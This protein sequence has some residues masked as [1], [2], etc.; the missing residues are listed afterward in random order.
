M[1]TNTYFLVAGSRLNCLANCRE[2]PD[3]QLFNIHE[4]LRV[5]VEDKYN[6]Q[7]KQRR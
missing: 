4:R 3:K 2:L 7:L 1:S 6:L 5:S